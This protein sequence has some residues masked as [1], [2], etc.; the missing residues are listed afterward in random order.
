MPVAAAVVAVAY[1]S[2]LIAGLFVS[3][4]GSGTAS[5]YPSQHL[6]MQRREGIGGGKLMTIESDHIGQAECRPHAPV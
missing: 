3:T 4:Q 1:Y 2:A 6:A 5:G